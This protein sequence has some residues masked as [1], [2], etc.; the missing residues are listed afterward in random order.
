MTF[1]DWLLS[2]DI[3]TETLTPELRAALEA[4]FEDEHSPPTEAIVLTDDELW[5]CPV[6]VPV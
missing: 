5:G 6:R 3:D 2:R 1:N 4:Q